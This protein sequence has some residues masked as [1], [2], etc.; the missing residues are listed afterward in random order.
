[1]K[2]CVIGAGIVGCATAYQLALQ[3]WEVHLLDQAPGAGRGTSFAN[4]AQLSYSYVEPLASPATLRGLPAMLLSSDS[5]LRLRLRADVHQWTWCLRFLQACT[6]RQSRLGTRELLLLAQL[7]RETLDSW[8][9]REDWRFSFQRNGKLV[10]CP[11]AESLRRQ[12]AQL[13]FQST[14]GCRQTLLTPQECVDREPALRTSIDQFAGGVWT[15]DECVGDP[16]ALSLEMTGSLQRLGGQVHFDTRV[17]GFIVIGD[18][19]AAALTPGG[20]FAADA[21]VIANGVEARR[22]AASVR[23]TL[24]IYPIKGYSITLPVRASDKAPRVSVTDLGRKTV[25]APL[26]GRLRVAA[27]AELVGHDLSIPPGRIQQMMDAARQM[28]PE[29]CEFQDPQPWAGLRPATPTAVPII[30]QRGP[31]NLYINAGHGALGFTLAAGS[32]QVLGRQMLDD[33]S[34]GVLPENS[35]GRQAWA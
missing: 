4:G 12:Q 13:Q 27:M 5:P 21:F 1:M 6:A 17:T 16:H 7:S 18:R 8:M 3:G 31:A 26:G 14:L 34:G 11:D 23:V 20:A 9:D 24:P 29:A 25:F 32:A 33:L 2:V 30:G 10:L 15:A 35:A 28:F 22:L 19:V